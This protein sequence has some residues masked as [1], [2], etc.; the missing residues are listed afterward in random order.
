MYVKNIFWNCPS[1]FQQ[2]KQQTVAF[3]DFLQVLITVKHLTVNIKDARHHE[4]LYNFC[5]FQMTND[6]MSICGEF[7]AAANSDRSHHQPP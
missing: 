2:M 3:L 6:E 5:Q 7:R 4:L 1:C